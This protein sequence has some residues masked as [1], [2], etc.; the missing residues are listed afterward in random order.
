MSL[1]SQI[2]ALAARIGAEDK[3]QNEAIAAME[4]L[5]EDISNSQGDLNV[6]VTDLV[7]AV[8]PSTSRYEPILKAQVFS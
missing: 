2:Q 6:A 3:A 5:V 4:S 7:T 1:V 8:G